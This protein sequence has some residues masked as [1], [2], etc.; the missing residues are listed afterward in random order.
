LLLL[1][2]VLILFKGWVPGSVVAKVDATIEKALGAPVPVVVRYR[3]PPFSFWI[4]FNV[5]CPIYYTPQS[6]ELTLL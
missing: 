2:G 4:H 3:N 6:R 5:A 1:G